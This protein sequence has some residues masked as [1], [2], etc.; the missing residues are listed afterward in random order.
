M[1]MYMF[2]ALI[3]NAKLWT[4]CGEWVSLC[5]LFALPFIL[6]KIIRLKNSKP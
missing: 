6:K 1:R 3:V 2:P 4:G 5:V